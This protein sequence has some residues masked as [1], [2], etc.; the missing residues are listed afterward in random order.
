MKMP[1]KDSA[2]RLHVLDDRPDP[3]RE[4]V[5][6]IHGLGLDLTSWAPIADDLA[7]A[8]FRPIRIDLRGHGGS[9]GPGFTL[10]NL[11]A[12]VTSVLDDR[13]IDRAHL[14]GH[15]LGGT[16]AAEV[17]LR[18]P[19]RALTVSVLGGLV[20]GAAP[21]AA[22]LAWTQEIAGLAKEGLP[23][24]TAA[25]PDTLMY[26]N[27]FGLRVRPALN[28]AGFIDQIFA[29][30]YAAATSTP[31]SWD[32]LRANAPAPVLLLNGVDDPGFVHSAAEL[33]AMVP[34]AR[35]VDLTGAGH[36]T[37]LEQPAVVSRHL[38]DFL[39]TGRH[40][41]LDIATPATHG[42]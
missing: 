32:R 19:E 28:D 37:V 21:S 13:Q 42:H 25:L 1:L 10:G 8:G 41:R 22:F 12:D 23:A 14:V 6:L 33:A 27:G 9:T 17:G 20:A 39:R 29:S 40:A 2:V 38:V 5:V 4:A 16:V 35:G 15:S 18:H 34:G 36:L 31:T 3:G 30:L 11:V 26:R 7:A 24:V